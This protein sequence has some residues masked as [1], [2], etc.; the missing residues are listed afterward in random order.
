MRDVNSTVTV[1]PERVSVRV[2]VD[3]LTAVTSPLNGLLG[4]PRLPVFDPSDPL[5]A[6]GVVCPL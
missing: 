1:A 4:V 2:S 5:V 6:T 3:P